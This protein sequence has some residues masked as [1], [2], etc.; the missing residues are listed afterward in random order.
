MSR[1]ALGCLCANLS[2][3]CGALLGFLSFACLLRDHGEA[4][5]ALSDFDQSSIWRSPYLESVFA[6]VLIRQQHRECAPGILRARLS[7]VV[8]AR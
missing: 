3:L 5:Q 1:Q 6:R 8:L 7:L 2:R 4:C